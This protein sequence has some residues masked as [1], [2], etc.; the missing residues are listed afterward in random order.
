MPRTQKSPMSRGRCSRARPARDMP[1]QFGGISHAGTDLKCA[2]PAPQAA[3]CAQLAR[4][5]L[6]AKAAAR[7]G[8]RPLARV[9]LS[10]PDIA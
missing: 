1:D 2:R 8:P 6:D 10:Q 7:K 4:P 9:Q 5:N 3:D